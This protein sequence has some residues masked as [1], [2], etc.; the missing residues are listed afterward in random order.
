MNRVVTGLHSKTVTA[1]EINN[2]NNKDYYG[3]LDR[4]KYYADMNDLIIQNE[5]MFNLRNLID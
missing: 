4:E 1:H 2:N 3:E 5:K